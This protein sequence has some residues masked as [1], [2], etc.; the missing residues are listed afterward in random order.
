LLIGTAARGVVISLTDLA[1][2]R[3]ALALEERCNDREPVDEEG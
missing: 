2:G 1:A 3:T